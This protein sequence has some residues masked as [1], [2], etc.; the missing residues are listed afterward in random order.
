MTLCVFAATVFECDVKDE[1]GL[2]GSERCLFSL[3]RSR[4]HRLDYF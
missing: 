1:A 2:E 3:Y 4:L